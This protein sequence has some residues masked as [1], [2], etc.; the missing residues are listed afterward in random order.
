MAWSDKD[1]AERF[2]EELLESEN[3]RRMNSVASKVAT[4]KHI[5]VDLRSEAKD[6]N[7]ILGN[8]GGLFDSAALLLGNSYK[9]VQGMR[10][11][12]GQNCKF[13][14]YFTIFVVV[15]LILVYFLIGKVISS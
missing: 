4:L 9:R 1:R 3:D 10:R 13:M 2:S 11:T 14:C 5:A 8:S 7:T 6:Q 15:F 12:R